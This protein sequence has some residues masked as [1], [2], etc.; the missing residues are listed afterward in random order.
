MENVIRL[1]GLFSLSGEIWKVNYIWSGSYLFAAHVSGDSVR[2]S[3][4]DSPDW[5]QSIRQ[6]WSPTFWAWTLAVRYVIL[7][8]FHIGDSSL[9]H[10][11]CKYMNVPGYARNNM[12]PN[13]RQCIPRSYSLFISPFMIS[14]GYVVLI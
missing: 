13:C 9:T 14:S 1:N 11:Q 4:P 2:V 5:N 12:T 3:T 6:Y 10:N 8:Q 7:I